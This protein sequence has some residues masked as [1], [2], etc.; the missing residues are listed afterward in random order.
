MLPTTH[1]SPF[2]HVTVL[3]IWKTKVTPALMWIQYDWNLI[4][5]KMLGICD[6]PLKPKGYS[7]WD[8]HLYKVLL[9]T[10][11]RPFSHVTVLG[12]CDLLLKPE[13]CQ[14]G[15]SHA[16]PCLEPLC[17]HGWIGSV[18]FQAYL[19][20]VGCE[21]VTLTFC[22]SH[23]CNYRGNYR[24]SHRHLWLTIIIKPPRE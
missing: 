9:S 20:R 1:S 13:Y 12:S 14:T 18:T 21:E 16:P 24:G 23:W 10:H 19:L 3:W 22:V 2:S 5:I 11:P 7:K 17:G 15:R 8:K 6:R 4:Q